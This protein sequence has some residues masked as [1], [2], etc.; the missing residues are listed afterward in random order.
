MGK[1]GNFFH[2]FTFVQILD[3]KTGASAFFF[4]SH[5]DIA[6]LRV[7]RQVTYFS[8]DSSGVTLMAGGG[9][10]F[11][12]QILHYFSGENCSERDSCSGSPH[13]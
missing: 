13:V 9:T 1:D 11:Q 8:L 5:P 10:F 2:F 12:H 6:M 7:K 4:R 3:G